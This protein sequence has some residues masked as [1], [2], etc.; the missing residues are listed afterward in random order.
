M[1]KIYFFILLILFI[2]KAMAQEK[3]YTALPEMNFIDRK[4]EKTIYEISTNDCFKNAPYKFFIVDMFL[5]DFSKNNLFIKIK[6]LIINDEV[7][8]NIGCYKKI[9]GKYYL[10]P[11]NV[12]DKVLTIIPGSSSFICLETPP[13]FYGGDYNFIIVGMTNTYYQVLKKTCSE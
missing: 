2:G 13:P 5:S 9:N 11:K 8:Q 1:R 4:L 7:I 6:P 12:P 3:K 10:F